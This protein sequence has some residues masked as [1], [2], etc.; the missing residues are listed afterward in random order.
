[1]DVSAKDNDEWWWFVWFYSFYIWYVHTKEIWLETLTCR[2][3]NA[4]YLK[5]T[6]SCSFHRGYCYCVIWQSPAKYSR[7]ENL[8]SILSDVKSFNRP[9]QKI[10]SLVVIYS[11]N[12]TTLFG[13]K[14]RQLH[15]FGSKYK[16]TLQ[17]LLSAITIL[18]E[19][20]QNVLKDLSKKSSVQTII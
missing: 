5:V 16:F 15:C 13:S 19:Q 20:K 6:H 9:W 4:M 3:L 2:P 14:T 12:S 8:W 1:M 17:L 7:M 18:F 11:L 10:C